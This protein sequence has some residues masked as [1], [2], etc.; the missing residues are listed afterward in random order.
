MA[1]AEEPAPETSVEANGLEGHRS[2]TFSRSGK[3]K[4]VSQLQTVLEAS[5]ELGV[6][7]PY[8]CRSGICGQCRTRLLGGRV[9]MQVTDALDP[10]DRGN[11][12]ILSCQA[13]CVDQ[14]TVEA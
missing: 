14:V 2:I 12:W 8:D 3:S 11:N 9:V 5:E 1:S 13:R 7:I 10:A 4:P 6:D